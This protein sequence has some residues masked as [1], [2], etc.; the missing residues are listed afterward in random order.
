MDE[1]FT[2]PEDLK[3]VEDLDALESQA[4]AEI[5]AIGEKAETTSEDVERVA[6]LVG[7]VKAIS[8]ERDTRQRIADE[9]QAALDKAMADLPAPHE[10]TAEERAEGEA[11][12]E[13]EA[14]TE[15]V[16]E[17]DETPAGDELPEPVAAGDKAKI[18]LAKDTDAPT[19]SVEDADADE[20]PATAVVAAASAGGVTAGDEIETA[21]FGGC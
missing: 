7:N 12:T 3:A 19:D 4:R 10:P 21:I 17:S 15:P 18:T 5:D 16:A 8:A 2:L 13:P 1:K 14:D 20:T 9:T 6:E 11:V